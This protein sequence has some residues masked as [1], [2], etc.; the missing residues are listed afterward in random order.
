V[1][2][3]VVTGQ[4]TGSGK[5]T[6]AMHLCEGLRKN[7]KTA[8]LHVTNKSCEFEWAK[9]ANSNFL[10]EH[11]N[12]SDDHTEIL[13]IRLKQLIYE[14]GHLVVDISGHDHAALRTVLK[15]ADKILMPT[16]GIEQDVK[17]VSELIA[18]GIALKPFHP[19]LQLYILFNKVPSET[20]QAAIE[21]NYQLLQDNPNATFL[22]TIIYYDQDIEQLMQSNMNIWERLSQKNN[23]IDAFINELLET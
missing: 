14:H 13:E 4:Q 21:Y 19:E 16:T 2:T 1:T 12:I 7:T 8:L 17:Y 9:Q 23:M 18:L 10:F 15:Y 22:K 11:L 6:I 3:F 5:T 20:T